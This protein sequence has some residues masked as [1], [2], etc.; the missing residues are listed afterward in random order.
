[1]FIG[2]KEELRQLETAFAVERSNLL[3]LY[4]RE[5]MGKTTLAL[6]FSE[7]KD[8]VYY[9]AAEVSPAEQ[10]RRIDACLLDRIKPDGSPKA[11][12][13]KKVLIIDEFQLAVCDELKARLT[14]LIDNEALYGRYMIL[15]L[16]SSINWVENSMVTA[17]KDIARRITGI[18]KLKELSFAEI[19]EWFPKSSASDCVVIRAVL[20]GIPKYLTLWQENR[21]IR[22]NIVSLF[23]STDGPLFGEAEHQLKTELREL[24]AYN[25][26]LTAL[27]SGRSK[28]NDIYAY[29][30]FNRA[31]ISVYLKNL[32]EMDI[33]EKM[34]SVNVRNSENTKKG[35]YRIK[36]SFINFYYAYVFPNTSMIECGQGKSV[37]TGILTPDFDRFMRKSFADVCREYLE[38]LSRYK[39]LGR[40][41]TEWHSWYGKKGV[42]DIIGV[43]ADKNMIVG[44]CDYSDRKTDEDTVDELKSLV[45]EA[46]IRPQKLCIFSKSGFEP[47]VSRDCND[48]NIMTVSLTDL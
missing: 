22:E 17:N 4:G 8:T 14:G 42:L 27:A 39:K 43:D 10:V 47:E 38:I 13:P 25:T 35:L 3:V 48:E 33:V 19:V 34:F 37:Y 1:M 45:V 30:G 29:T 9:R 23:F 11:D 18:I 5:G 15:L 41:Y 46:G 6:K 12:S 7:G 26:I 28:L 31:K 32:S 24:G 20:G 2:R 36:D 21:R 44:I 16:S 40:V